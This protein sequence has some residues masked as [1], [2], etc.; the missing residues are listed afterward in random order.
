M[1]LCNWPLNCP[2]SSEVS[3]TRVGCLAARPTNWDVDILTPQ[4]FTKS[5]DTTVQ[6]LTA[7][8]FVDEAMVDKLAA[9]GVISVFDV[10]EVGPEYLEETLGLPQEQIAQ[11]LMDL[12]AD[13]RTGEN[14]GAWVGEDLVLP[15]RPPAHRRISG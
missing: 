12:L 5:M 9:L 2:L 14:I 7:M 10:E 3:I 6:T 11:L 13:G 1:R 15:A 4:E 8:D